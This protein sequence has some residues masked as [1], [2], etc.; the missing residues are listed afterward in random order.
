ETAEIFAGGSRVGRLTSVAES[1]TLRAPVGLALVRREVVP[2]SEVEVRW[3]GGSIPATVRQLPLAN[4][5]EF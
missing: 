4:F 5:T 3:E 1:L 2:G